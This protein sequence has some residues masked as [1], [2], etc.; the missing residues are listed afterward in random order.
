VRF[1]IVVRKASLEPL[2]IWM[3]VNRDDGGKGNEGWVAVLFA[4][5]AVTCGDRLESF[6][7][8]T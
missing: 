2:E 7:R 8:I 6:I 1:F 3:F 5:H 4:V